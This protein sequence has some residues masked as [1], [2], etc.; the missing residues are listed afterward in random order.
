[1]CIHQ[2]PDTADILHYTYH[3]A[4]VEQ[5]DGFK[6]AKAMVFA[7]FYPIDPSQY[8]E[9]RKSYVKSPTDMRVDRQTC[10]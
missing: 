10:V 7:S 1:M 9:L 6:K 2:T 8:D 5:L 3:C 4:D